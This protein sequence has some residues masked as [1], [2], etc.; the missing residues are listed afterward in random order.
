[1]RVPGYAV[2]RLDEIERRGP[3]AG[4]WHYP[5]RSH[6]GIASFGIGA[7]VAD[8]AG[9]AVIEEHDET[10]SLAGGHEE[11]YLVVHGHATFTVGGQEADAPTGTL[12]FVRDPAARRSAV[13]REPGTT[14]L[15]IGA[16]AGQAFEPAPWESI[17]AFWT[18][19]STGDYDGAIAVLEQGLERYRDNPG[20]LFNLA[21]CESLAGRLDA[22]LGHLRR[23]VEL[24]DERMLDMAQTDEDLGPLRKDPRFQELVG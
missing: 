10:G 11:L 13:A 18:P 9:V 3:F 17:A 22:A 2:S 19:Y 5:V 8:E 23:A 6:F 15:A 14:V 4:T 16:V 12:V 7:Y 20:M 1:M 24:G 21:C